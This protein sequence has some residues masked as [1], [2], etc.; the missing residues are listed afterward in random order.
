MAAVLHHHQLHPSS[1][2]LYDIHVSDPAKSPAMIDLVLPAHNEEGSIAATLTEFDEV[3]RGKFGLDI[4]FVVCEDGSTDR[5][6]AIIQELAAKLPILLLSAPQRKGYSGA[7]TDGL[8]ATTAPYVAFI[9]SDGQCDPQDI[10]QFVEVKDRCDLV[11]GYR[12]PRADHW[13]RRVMSGCFH[14]GYS[15]FFTV[16]FRDPSCPYLLINRAA[17]D[18]LLEGNLGIF[19][20]GF[21]WEFT[22]R[23]AAAGL[24]SIEVPV[25]HR[26]RTAGS[27]QVY[28]PATIARIAWEH[29]WGLFELK[30]EL[31]SRYPRAR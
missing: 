31:R 9:D 27:T 5:T 10:K 14:A 7:V 22:A 15:L 20:Q 18:R 16:P 11:M 29:F 19:K 23:A 13:L 25:T 24:R 4:R 12:N 8:R 2:V 26:V 28:K 17:L 3:A 30:R 21:W 6:V 1:F